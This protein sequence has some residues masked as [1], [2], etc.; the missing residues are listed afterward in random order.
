MKRL[1]LL[2]ILAACSACP[3]A[4]APPPVTNDP[5]VRTSVD[6]LV[7]ILPHRE[8][9]LR[10]SYIG[11]TLLVDGWVEEM[12]RD[13]G[14]WHI[15]LRRLSAR[16]TQTRCYFPPGN[17]EQLDYLFKGATVEL[18][19]DCQGYD[20]EQ[21]AVILRNCRLIVRDFNHPDEQ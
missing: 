18:V 20:E 2:A 4:D 13:A 10:E 19:G 17:G 14:G 21:D 3:A 9:G 7:N 15:V 12:G 1:A 11:K 6:W 16:P 8:D 5:V